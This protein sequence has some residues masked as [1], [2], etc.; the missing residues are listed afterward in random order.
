MLP[1]YPL[2]YENSAQKI[3]LRMATSR[4]NNQPIDRKNRRD[5]NQSKIANIKYFL[6]LLL[7]P[8]DAARDIRC[9][10]E[11]REA[12]KQAAGDTEACHFAKIGVGGVRTRIF[13]L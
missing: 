7:L 4:G 12:S 6:R 3:Y 5:R 2:F 1:L 8:W 11:H 9:G 10:M 13:F